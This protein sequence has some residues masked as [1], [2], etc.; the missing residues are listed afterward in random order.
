M[1]ESAEDEA[2]GDI[3][4]VNSHY[5]HPSTIIII[6]GTAFTALKNEL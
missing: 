1:R 3:N 2:P 4:R 5:H 6:I